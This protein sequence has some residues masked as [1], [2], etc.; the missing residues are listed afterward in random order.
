MVR[1]MAMDGTNTLNS[2]L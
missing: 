1:P 2:T